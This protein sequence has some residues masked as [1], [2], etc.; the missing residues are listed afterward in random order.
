MIPESGSLHVR[1][2]GDRGTLGAVVSAWDSSDATPLTAEIVP[3][4]AVDATAE[5][6]H[7]CWLLTDA[8]FETL[9]R[10]YVSE[11]LV[12][13]VPVVLLVEGT[14]DATVRDALSA[15][16]TETLPL[17]VVT[18]DPDLA[19]DHVADL[20]ER[21]WSERRLHLVAERI[22]QII[23]LTN[24]DFSEVFYVDPAYEAITGYSAA[25]LSGDP[26][27]FRE[28]VHE[29][30]RERF[31]GEIEAMVAELTDPQ[32]DPQDSYE[33]EW[34]SRTPDGEV[35]WHRGTSYPVFDATPDGEDRLVTITEDV[36]ER[37]ELERTYRSVFEGVSDGLVV[38]DPETGEILD[39]NGRFCELT[40]Y[41]E[42]ELVGE[43]VDVVTAPEYSYDEAQERIERARR[44]GPQL[45]EW[46][47]Q[48]K[49]GRTYVAEVHLAVAEIRGDER[50]LAS[51]RDVSE[52]KQRERE[53]EQIFDGVNDAISV[54]DPE[55]G[56]MVD[57]N[58]SLCDLLGYERAELLDRGAEAISLAE[59]GYDEQR[60][61]EFIESVVESGEAKQTEWK[62]ETADDEVRWLEV[63][64][65]TATI[66]GEERYIAIDRDVTEQRRTKRRLQAILDRIDEAIFLAPV[67]DLNAP[68]PAPDFV[69]SGYPEIWG[70]PL[71]ELL[72]SHEEG[73]FGTL[74]PEDEAGY[75]AFMESIMADVEAGT[76]ADSYAREYRIE[77]PDGEV[78]WIHSDYYPVEW[79]D[80]PRI[81]IVSRDVTERK[82]RER[83]MAS[84]EDATD[85]LATADTAAEATR[86]G[87][88][89]AMDTLA[90]SAVGV[91]LYDDDAGR[92]DPEVVA[93]SMPP[94]IESR[95]VGPGDGP[96]W[97]AFAAGS[98]VTPADDGAVVPDDAPGDGDPL[99]DWRGL[100]LGNH[101]VLLVGSTDGT[102]DADTIQSAH[103]LA[104]TLEAA[105]NRLHGQRRLA[106]QQEQ[107]ETQTRRAERLDRI[108]RLTQQVEAAITEASDPAEVE[109]A[110]CERLA[111]S[112]P[113]AVAW[114]GGV[115][116]GA[117]RLTAR[118][119]VG[120][121]QQYVDGLDLT[122]TAEGADPHPA[123]RA[124]RGDE[125]AVVSSLVDDG[126]TGEW[127]RRALADGL[128]SLCAIPLTYDGI[129]HG[130]LTVGA[131][132][133]NAFGDREA[134]V[135][136]QLG[137]SVGYAL[138]AI[139]R[140]RALQ[141]DETVE[142]EFSGT[143]RSIQFVRAARAGECRVRHERT[144]PREGGDVSVYFG[145]EDP[146]DP[147]AAVQ[148]LPGETEVVT[149]DDGSRLVETRTDTWF[150]SPLAEYGAV[151]REATATPEE[152]TLVVEVPAG[153]DVRSFV[154]RVRELAPSLELTAKRHHQRRGRTADELRNAVE[155]ELTDRQFEALTTALSAGYFEWPREHDGSDVAD[156]LGITQP[157][158]NKHLRH[159][160]RKAFELVFG[161][162]E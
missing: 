154:E 8:A 148:Q 114:V 101:G 42:A 116:V 138:A 155:D 132:T 6:Y 62:V 26:L 29:D 91:F 15:G 90:L 121:A 49:D 18:G 24:L 47:E 16:I 130:I 111:G 124:W 44:E 70:R 92:L 122:K 72:D 2:V 39:V 134:D 98:T 135:L 23:Y 51:V 31:L 73:F 102:L 33:F 58:E 13:D 55:T 113:Y 71:E 96:L 104:G 118:A 75:R 66:G 159:A 108:A 3:P 76:A 17:G 112:G 50:V 161:D 36:T 80:A 64:G 81:V 152:T 34:R 87:V 153:T 48:T 37:R 142:L 151:L 22:D 11:A 4:T 97:D 30:D 93:G 106:A 19:A 143:G 25:D 10:E 38:H 117:D 46:R 69:S 79:D 89:A 82:A 43:T 110:V 14:N 145:V 126:A 156:R 68:D 129:T 100:A 77:R 45:F 95:S 78:R 35:R 56:E 127:R 120:T 9:G 52:R 140:R 123:L 125:V 99:D 27:A 109:R 5:R 12:G 141:S 85:D 59:D 84:F 40:G 57:A 28:G 53:Y 65:T 150:G 74:H 60:A 54:H 63:N 139:E 146:A 7:D 88:R 149:D 133:P 162:S 144:V 1:V 137:T 158:L 67:S 115:G 131:T 61:M 86:K 160:E 105:L 21:E 20:V 103:V 119:V 94:A 136:G 107:L 157:T 128:Q 32:R 83:R 147:D 41:S